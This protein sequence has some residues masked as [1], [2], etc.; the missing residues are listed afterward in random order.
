MQHEFVARRA[1]EHWGG[2]KGTEKG[3]RVDDQIVVWS[4]IFQGRAEVSNY[5]IMAIHIR[6]AT[7][8][9]CY[10][11]VLIQWSNKGLIYIV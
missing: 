11:T 8:D 1:R 10:C 2:R 4:L 9:N 3:R 7:I 6:N 5:S